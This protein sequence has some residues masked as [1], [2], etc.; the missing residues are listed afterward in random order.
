M[1]ARSLLARAEAINA[2]VGR[3]LGLSLRQRVAV[4]LAD[5]DDAANGF[6]NPLPYNAIHLRVVTP[7]DMSPLADYDDWFNTLLTHEHTHIV[8]LEQSGGI[9]RLIQQI[10]GRIYTPQH[11][12]PG[13]LV[14]GLAV[15]EESEHTSGGRIRSSQFEMYL[16]LD[17]LEQR[18][19][20]LDWVTFEGE[21]WPHGN[22]RYVYGSA[23]MQF[24]AE[25][26]G[27]VAFGAFIREYGRRLVPFGLN[28]ALKR[29]TGTTF[30]ALYPQFLDELKRRAEA[31]RAEVEQAGRIEGVRRTFHGEQT[32]S[33]R[34]LDDDTL[35]Y[36]VA[37][38]RHPAALRLLSLATGNS[39]R[40]TRVADTAQS[41][42][43]RTSDDV[44]YSALAIHRGRYAFYEL[45]RIG[46][47]AEHRQQL[48]EGARA[49]EPDVSP[50]GKRVV[51]VS[52]GAGT[53]HLEIADLADIEGTRRIVVRSRT[54]EQV[55]TPRF[56]PDGRRVAY[57]AWTRGGY[58][59]IW[60]LDIASGER[61]RLTYDRAIDRGPVFS[62]DGETL[63][64]SSDRTGI[65][66][67]Y[68]YRFDTQHLTQ[69]TNVVG[70]AF[71]PDVS[72]SGKQLVYVGYTS[73]GFDLYTLD[74]S[75]VQERTIAP[76]FERAA[77]IAFSPPS[78]IASEVYR[79]YPTLYPR[80]YELAL[81]QGASGQR[82]V[83]TTGGADVVGF[84]AYSLRIAQDLD[85]NKRTIGFSYAYGRT[86]F[87]FFLSGSVQRDRI[88]FAID[89]RNE[90]AEVR[91]FQLSVGT[92]FGFP[93]PLRAIAVRTEYAVAH[94]DIL[95]ARRYDLDPSFAPP[96]LPRGGTDSSLSASFTYSTVQRQPYDISNSYGQSLSLWSA[97][98]EPYLGA[99][100]RSIA[101]GGRAEQ[102]VRFDFR[103]SV[104]AF[105]Y[106]AQWHRSVTLG[107]YAAQIQPILD[108]IVQGKSAPG[109]Y[110]RLRGF[111]PRSGDQLQVAQAEYRLLIARIN[112]GL[113][114]LPIFARRVHAAIF[115]DAG[116]AY[117]GHFDPKRVGVGV[118]AEL[119]LDWGGGLSYTSNYTLRAG[120]ARG[121][122]NGGVFQ[123]YLTLALPF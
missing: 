81:D 72:P 22:V 62:P 9:P 1:L 32:R 122:T 84:H 31:K 7:D 43:L 105:A 20:P 85:E 12:L 25:R 28:R 69:I 92:T 115:V 93:G 71:Q 10:F 121:V 46:R 65:A 90:S 5:D 106:T 34:F 45:Y 42:P 112:R 119:R 14:E 91:N 51:F 97:Y 113:S 52:H 80:T 56:S 58:R 110:A 4:V 17:A 86:R 19:L 60:V 54:L 59:D 116:D 24:I 16:R 104:L 38:A 50:D 39:E 29:V 26:Y 57:G 66:N 83:V 55:F 3:S 30:D 107:G 114:T 102:F 123:W 64:F 18:L 61:T 49:R 40:L 120:I 87:P 68:A 98:S 15:V 13:W 109:D 108:T 44:L 76:S 73:K 74:L 99:R 118:G 117:V 41:A 67:L 36:A 63:Y 89:Q 95:D 21:P 11:K 88:A 33:P 101:L 103:E 6:A 70:G 23:F 77:P 8:H 53:S 96:N 37:D 79:P 35:S 94:S 111:Q 75:T 27:T 47:N 82:L 2:K 48:T 100:T 78:E